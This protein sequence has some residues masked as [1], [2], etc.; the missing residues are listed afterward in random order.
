[1]WRYKDD[2][3]DFSETTQWV[4][5]ETIVHQQSEGPTIVQHYDRKAKKSLGFDLTWVEKTCRLQMQ[6]QMSNYSFIAMFISISWSI[7]VAAVKLLIESLRD[8][9]G[10]QNG[11]IFGKVPKVSMFSWGFPN[12]PKKFSLASKCV[13]PPG[14]P[15]GGLISNAPNQSG[16]PT[17]Q[18]H[19]SHYVE[20]SSHHQL[21]MAVI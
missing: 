3:S 14:C 16:F 21:P 13:S 19:L 12:Y 20:R 4:R 11:L 8:A 1:M 17:K 15:M 2:N 10:Y 6:M 18:R 9:F 5:W 7:N